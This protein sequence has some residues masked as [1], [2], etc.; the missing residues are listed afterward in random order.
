MM[1]AETSGRASTSSTR[2][3]RLE[4][5]LLPPHLEQQPLARQRP[6]VVIPHALLGTRRDGAEDGQPAGQ[7]IAHEPAIARYAVQ[8]AGEG[9]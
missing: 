9:G 3:G 8:S 1:A 5:P 6:A 4:L 2:W 7:R